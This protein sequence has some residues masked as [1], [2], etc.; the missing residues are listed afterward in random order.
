M[1]D[2]EADHVSDVRRG[3]VSQDGRLI[4]E[5]TVKQGIPMPG[6]GDQHLARRLLPPR[7]RHPAHLVGHEPARSPDATGGAELTLGDHPIADELRSLGLP[8]RALATTTIPDL[9]MTFGDA[10][11][12]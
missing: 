4:A 10:P 7:R 6:R 12:V 11:T 2:F 8:R 3:R 5:L 1:A 9:R